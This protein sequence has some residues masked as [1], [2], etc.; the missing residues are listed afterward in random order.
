MHIAENYGADSY[1]LICGYLFSQGKAA[2][3]ITSAQAQQWLNKEQAEKSHSF[4]WLHFNLSH[5]ASEKWINQ[6]LDLPPA[7][8]ET[9]HEGSRTT[10]IEHADQA[11]V[12]VV[13]DVLYGFSFDPSEISTLWLTA[14]DQYLISARSKPL[15]SV[16]RLRSSV[17][18]GELFRSPVELLIHLLRDQED[19]LVNIVREATARVDLI[20]DG[21]L[22]KKIAVKRAE[23]STLRRVLVRLQRLLA[24][25]PT[26]MFRFLHRPPAWIEELDLIE[27]RQSTEEFAL[28]LNDMNALAE[29]IKLLQEEMA[30]KINEETNKS[31]FVLTMV[32][33]LALPINLIAGLFG[34]NVA[35][36]PLSNE[37]GGFWV[38]IAIVALVT[39]VIGMLV[40]RFIRAQ[41]DA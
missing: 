37:K 5:M 2:Q 10:R 26:A 40:I 33:V 17:R 34:M 21:L 39:A 1:G 18:E 27:F 14:T 15:L 32:T 7:F 41:R 29:R 16:D 28:A 8:Y 25:E 3:E 36:I 24:L 35:G 23:L 12:A 11:L 19:V 6:H 38:V 31:L 22:S 9:L 4:M 20:E 13:N 30:A